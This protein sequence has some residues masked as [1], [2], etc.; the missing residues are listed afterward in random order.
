MESQTS[1]RAGVPYALFALVGL[2]VW[3]FFQASMTIGTASV[4]TNITF[5]RFTPCPRP[6]FPIAGVIASLPSFA[7]TATAALVAAAAT[8][9]LSARAVLLPLGLVWLLVLTMGVVAIIVGARGRST[10]TSSARFP[11][12]LQVGVFFAPIGYSLAESLAPPA[13]DRR[14][15]IR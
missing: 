8:G 3:A 2:S 6:A 14:V 5:V 7:V 4:V 15:S 11:F 12:L 1:R 9:D 13:R 10:A